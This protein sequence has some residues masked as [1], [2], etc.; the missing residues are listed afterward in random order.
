MK[1]CVHVCECE[2]VCVCACVGVRARYVN[3][4]AKECVIE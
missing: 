1:E 4:I 2:R 3:V